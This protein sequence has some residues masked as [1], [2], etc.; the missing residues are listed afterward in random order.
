[1][2]ITLLLL[3]IGILIQINN[4]FANSTGKM[5][6]TSQEFTLKTTPIYNLGDILKE[7]KDFVEIPVLFPT[8]IKIEPGKIYF[9]HSDIQENLTKANAKKRYSI[10]VGY[11]PGCVAHYCT[12]GYVY[13]EYK[14]QITPDHS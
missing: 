7:V 11:T 9:A 13:A 8:S 12:L 5:I 6:P 1:M 14:G 10:T 3:A 4:C 2:K